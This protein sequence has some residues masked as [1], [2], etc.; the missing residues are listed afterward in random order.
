MMSQHAQ[1]RNSCFLL[2]KLA[3]FDILQAEFCRMFW[4]KKEYELPCPS[5]MQK[6]EEFV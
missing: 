6:E 2:A 1:D 4:N 3:E 5:T